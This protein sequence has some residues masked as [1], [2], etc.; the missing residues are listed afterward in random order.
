MDDHK[1]VEQRRVY[2]IFFPFASQK[3]AEARNQNMR[4]VHYSSAEAAMKL[5]SGRELWMRKS[6]FMNDFTEIEHGRRCLARTFHGPLG[7]RFLAA[8]DQ[9]AAGLGQ[10]AVDIFNSW[11]PDFVQN[12]FLACFSEH[13]G[14]HEDKFGRLSMW[15][16][17]GGVTGVAMVI[18]G[19][20]FV[21]PSDALQAT[22]SP[23]AYL[24]PDDFEAKFAEVTDGIE[25][26]VDLLATRDR[27][28]VREHVI[29]MFRYV[30]ICTKHPGF[31]EELEW[32]IIYQPNYRASDHICR[33]V[34]TIRGVPQPVCK[35]PLKNIPG[36]DGIE[37]PELIDRIIIGPTHHAPAMW[38]A[39]VE[40]LKSAGVDD[41]ENKVFVSSIPLR[42]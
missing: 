2:E 20:P 35:I 15:R 7:T 31:K 39:F 29:Q 17:Y 5:L 32:R 26:N 21:T 25:A 9:I 13:R 24:G 14:G 23:V 16:A 10:E 19:K 28:A 36:L 34:E 18:H 42:Q 8:L 38:E 1:T 22:S 3:L 12:T 37:V 30:T 40:T 33:T 41:A 11:L 6:S 27:A 4:F